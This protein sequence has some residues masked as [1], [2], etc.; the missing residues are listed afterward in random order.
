MVP[1]NN[2]TSLS[3]RNRGGEE[4]KCVVFLA[5]NEKSPKLVL[6]RSFYSYQS[7]GFCQIKL[8]G[9]IA[10]QTYRTE[11]VIDFFRAGGEKKKQ[12]AQ[13]AAAE[14]KNRRSER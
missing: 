4:K 9:Y 12:Q 1:T 6:Q 10:Q 13:A 5:I 7:T 8:V 11:N 3:V 14:G 2:N